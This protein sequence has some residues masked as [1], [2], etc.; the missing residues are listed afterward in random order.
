VHTNPAPA[1]CCIAHA[2]RASA[3]AM[4]CALPHDTQGTEQGSTGP[5]CTTRCPGRGYKSMSHKDVTAQMKLNL[6]IAT[7]NYNS[8]SAY[9]CRQPPLPQISYQLVVERLHHSFYWYGH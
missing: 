8:P 6:L 2:I 9:Q 1:D 5:R 7:S 3:L 4:A